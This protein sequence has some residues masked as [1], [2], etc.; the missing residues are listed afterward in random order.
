MKFVHSMK[1]VLS[2][3]LLLLPGLFLEPG[4]RGSLLAAEAYS[5]DLGNLLKDSGILF[6]P[7]RDM[8][9]IHNVKRGGR[10][11]TILA[12]EEGKKK[13]RLEINFECTRETANK[14]IADQQMMI[15]GLHGEIRTGYPGMITK[16]IDIPDE[17]KPIKMEVD[18]DG[19]VVDAMLLRA[20]ERL[21]YGLGDPSQVVYGTVMAFHYS[22]SAKMLVQLE[23]FYPIDDFSSEQALKEI[24]EL[25]FK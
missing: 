18:T 20:S 16:K 12:G 22:D 9:V 15:S 1:T 25:K 6:P 19:G 4:F 24:A 14:I 7:G 11:A 10:F 3:S 21:S 17:L 8:T 13:A 2:L 5:G 23:L